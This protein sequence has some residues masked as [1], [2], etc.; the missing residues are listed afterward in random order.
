MGEE[1]GPK[2]DR[3]GGGTETVLERKP[4]TKRPKLFRVLLH[5]DDYTTMEF[6]VYVLQS[7]FHK[8]EA[9]ATHLMLT[10]HHKGKGIA[11]VFT[12]DIAESKVAQVIALAQ[13]H[14]MPL[15]CTS[16][17]DE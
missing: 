11:G 7:V 14:S 15:M 3:P 13:E 17:P 8:S 10:I 16:E 9:E 5:N 1:K 4:K 12:L 2:V 6:V